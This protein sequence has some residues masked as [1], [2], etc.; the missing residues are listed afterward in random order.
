MEFAVD[1]SYFQEVEKHVDLR[2]LDECASRLFPYQQR[3][4]ELTSV[5]P[6]QANHKSLCGLDGDFVQSICQCLAL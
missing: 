2:D 4:S 3:Y 5:E 6:L 1:L